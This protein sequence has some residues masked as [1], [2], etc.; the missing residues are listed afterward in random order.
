MTLDMNYSKKTPHSKIFKHELRKNL[1]YVSLS[2]VVIF[3]AIFYLLVQF[4][5]ANISA[6]QN[7]A[8]NR[9]INH[10]LSKQLDHYEA[11]ILQF[12]D[13]FGF[14]LD[15]ID[16]YRYQLNESLYGFINQQEIRGMFRLFN[17]DGEVLLT[18]DGTIQSR[19]LESSFLLGIYRR[20]HLQPN[21]LIAHK[22]PIRFNTDINSTL[23]IGRGIFYEDKCVGYLVF[24]ILDNDLIN[25]VQ[26]NSTDIVVITDHL[27][28]TILTTDSTILNNLGKFTPL[29][30]KQNFTYSIRN[31]RHFV[32]KSDLPNHF[33]SV[34]TLTSH[35]FLDSLF[36]AGLFLQVLIVSVSIIA[37]ILV[38]NHFANK[39]TQS[40]DQLLVAIDKVRHGDFNTKLNIDSYRE[41][42]LVSTYFNEMIDN[43][44]LL[45]K[46]NNELYARNNISEMRQLESQFNPHFLFNALESLKYLI[47]LQSIDAEK[48]VMKLA[49]I[50]RYSISTIENFTSLEN[51]LKHIQDY[52]DIQKI[53]Y[54]HRLTYTIEVDSNCYSAYIPKLMI[55][56]I[57][58]NCIQH[59]YRQERMVI[60]IAVFS[61]NNTLNL[62]IEDNGNGICADKLITLQKNLHAE[63]NQTQHIGLYNVHRRLVLQYGK[64][65]GLSIDSSHG[66]NTVVTIRLPLKL[67]E[68]V[69]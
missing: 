67:N 20:M 10:H 60:K 54:C 16:T 38:A 65:Y 68:V 31:Q 2:I 32:F 59:G 13:S 39:N 4:L 12:Q 43:F 3:S 14:L 29:I 34:Y 49:G 25:F 11:Y 52:L 51:D 22:N 56:P 62:I 17:A 55:Q 1:L 23:S 7:Q 48:F 28:N 64:Q 26:Q 18:S 30:S 40:L 53:R 63:S 21:L 5:G 69:L 47:R 27:Q 24:Y 15:D 46:Q 57:I 37:I 50:L 9:I 8:N 61:F 44:V 35:Q 36:L 41:F 66:K 6:A 19:T 33:L 45:I 58:E 42:A